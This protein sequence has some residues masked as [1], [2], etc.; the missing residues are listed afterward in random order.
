MAS[1]ITVSIVENHTQEVKDQLERAIQTALKTVGTQAVAHAV[2]EITAVGAVDTGRLR[3][4]ITSEVEDKTVYLGTNVYY[5][6]YVE[7]GTGIYAS[8]GSGRKSSWVY[9]DEDGNWH[10]TSGMKAR[11]FIK[12]AIE[13]NQSEYRQIFEEALKKGV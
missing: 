11:P 13:K 7:L 12:P 8:N 6:P 2:E 10:R 1:K 5:A 9:K 4:S 3:S